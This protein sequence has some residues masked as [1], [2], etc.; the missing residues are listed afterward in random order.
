M[1]QAMRFTREAGRIVIV[2]Q[3]IR[4]M[5]EFQPQQPLTPTWTLTR[6]TSTCA[7]AGVRIFSHFYRGVQIIS[8]AAR[9]KP[10]L[11]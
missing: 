7:V 8:D 3:S 5:V 4:I 9:A 2:G 10:W 6:S 1:V 11:R